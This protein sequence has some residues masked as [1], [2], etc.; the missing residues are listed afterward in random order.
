MVPPSYCHLPELEAR[1]TCITSMTSIRLMRHFSPFPTDYQPEAPCSYWG[2]TVLDKGAIVCVTAWMIVMCVK[3]VVQDAIACLFMFKNV[4]EHDSHENV[5]LFAHLTIW[6]VL[7]ITQMNVCFFAN[8][9]PWTLMIVA[10]CNWT[11]D[12]MQK[13]LLKFILSNECTVA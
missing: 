11:L 2:K 13:S 7:M 1:T 6:L 8:E 5:C 9:W 3:M 10:E 4:N 12:N